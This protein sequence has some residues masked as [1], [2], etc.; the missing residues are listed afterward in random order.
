MQNVS[1][2]NASGT[3]QRCNRHKLRSRS[4]QLGVGVTEIP[5]VVAAE[6]ARL[7]TENA[8]LLKMLELSPSVWACWQYRTTGSGQALTGDT[9]GTDLT[10]DARF[11]CARLR[12]YGGGQFAVACLYG[13][14][15]D[16]RDLG[17]L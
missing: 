6:L 3:R 8:R 5:A 12:R 1:M 4:F 10:H 15:G 14:L 7:R 13:Q 16:R 17:Y 9:A 11:A 2:T